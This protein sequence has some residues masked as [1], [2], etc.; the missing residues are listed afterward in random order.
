[1]NVATGIGLPPWLAGMLRAIVLA[2]LFAAINAAIQVL[3]DP[4]VGEVVA[5]QAVIVLIL[6]QVEASLDQILRPQMNSRTPAEV[7]R[8]E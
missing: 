7:E 4:T 5:Y 3:T 6:R 1:M 2:V 8:G